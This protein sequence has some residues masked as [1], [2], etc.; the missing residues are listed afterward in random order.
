MQ[1][2]HL[3][4]SRPSSFALRPSRSRGSRRVMAQA[5]M[6]S[7]LARGTAVGPLKAAPGWYTAM[8]PDDWSFATP[9]GGVLMTVALRAMRAELSSADLLPVSATT[10]FCSP[11]PAGPLEI[12]VETLRKS[13]GAAQMR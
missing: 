12:R 2:R 8:L 9:S 7:D 13:G 5:V 10:V 4:V 1:H 11:V 3:A 6:P